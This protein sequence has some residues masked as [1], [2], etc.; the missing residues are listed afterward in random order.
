MCLA[1][2]TAAV[3]G[4]F[5][6]GCCCETLM[7]Y[8]VWQNTATSKSAAWKMWRPHLTEILTCNWE[9]KASLEMSNI[10][11]TLKEST[12][13]K[14]NDFPMIFLMFKPS[15]DVS[16][17]HSHSNVSQAPPEGVRITV[18]GIVHPKMKN[19]LSFSPHHVISNLNICKNCII[20]RHLKVLLWFYT[21][22]SPGL[23]VLK[24]DWSSS[25]PGLLIFSPTAVRHFTICI[26]LLVC[27][28]GDTEFDALASFR[29]IFIGNKEIYKITIQIQVITL[30]MVLLI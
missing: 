14:T 1:A 11:G 6:D 13:I 20:C 28:L 3:V 9:T 7:S 25:A 4:V 19:L 12:F 22:I 30:T 24:S 27:V 18:K 10:F 2:C 17:I 16:L 8:E 29:S 15:E 21:T 5:T 26:T 23:P